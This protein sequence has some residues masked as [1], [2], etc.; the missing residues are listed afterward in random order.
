MNAIKTT[1]LMTGLIVLFTLFGNAVGGR[2][3]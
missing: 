3:G 2:E 1:L